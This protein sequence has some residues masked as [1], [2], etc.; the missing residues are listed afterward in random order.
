MALALA[1]SRSLADAHEAGLEGSIATGESRSQLTPFVLVEDDDYTSLFEEA[2]STGSGYPH[3][4]PSSAPS[5]PTRTLSDTHTASSS[6]SRPVWTEAELDKHLNRIKVQ[7]LD[8]QD[9]KASK[10]SLQGTALWQAPRAARLVESMQQATE[11]LVWGERH[12]ASL[13][14]LFCEHR[15]LAAFVTALRAVI[16]VQVKVQILQTL[17]ILVQNARRT[18]SF[19][20]LIE[21]WS[22]QYPFR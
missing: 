11:A 9:A 16:P 8:Q 14:D 7:L 17:S 22:A 21:W 1:W 6:S 4:A 20:F 3:S 10:I 13:F 5:S 12:D 19:F 2:D 15:M 18:T